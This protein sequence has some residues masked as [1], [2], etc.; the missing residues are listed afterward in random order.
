[1]KKLSQN[2]TLALIALI[3]AAFLAVPLLGGLGLQTAE[4]KAAKEFSAIAATADDHGNDIFSDTDMLIAAASA[5]LDEGIRLNEG[6]GSEF[7]KWAG[8]LENAIESCRVQ[9]DAIGRYN[10]YESLIL[11]ARRFY[12]RIKSSEHSELAACMSRL[13][14]QSDGIAR[15]YRYKYN[16][17]RTKCDELVAKWPA[18]MI[19]K[20]FGIGGKM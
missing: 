8:E 3:A 20:L 11:T 15:A 5:L 14:A 9:K 4:R 2:R 12:S 16:D 18:S 7:E 19:A 17:Y 1:M 13:E 6:G 10:S